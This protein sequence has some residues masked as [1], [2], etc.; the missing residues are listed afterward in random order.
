MAKTFKMVSATGQLGSGFRGESIDKAI[1]LGAQ[2]V[3]CDAGSTDTGPYPLATGRPQ[4]SKA[5]VKRD[6]E[7]FLT[8]AVKAKI[9]VVIG[10]SGTGGNDI[11]VEWQ[12][13]I[14]REIARENGLHFTMATV[15]SE[16]KKETL[17]KLLAAGKTRPLQ[18]AAPLT[19]ENIDEATHVVAMMGAEPIQEAYKQGAQV[20]VCGRASDTSIFASLP[21][22]EG[23]APEYCWHA[24][25]ILECGAAAVTQ[26]TAPDSMM[27]IVN[28]DS[29][30]IFPIREDYRCSPQSIASHT[31]YENADP[32]HLVEPSG[33]LVT[34]GC[35]YEAID[36]R[37]VRV[38]GS[39][40]QHAKEYTNKLE[41]TRLVGYSTILPGA[42]RD[43]LILKQLDSWLAGLDEAIKVRL[44]TTL[45]PDAKYKIVTRVYGRD[46]V[47]GELEPEPHVQGHEVMILWD[48]IADTQELAH[49][50]GS[51]VMHL[52]AHYPIPEWHG[53][54]T[55]VAVPFAPPEV[56]RGP[57]Y[58][59]HLNHVV[60][61][62][63]PTSLFPIELEKV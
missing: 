23:F 21:L 1:A 5:A 62:D 9:P 63:S 18:P 29:F 2:M 50:V 22:L 6:T 33:T 40:F 31:L 11:G 59:F 15:H 51:S 38:R 49:S 24:A 46:G 30:D 44:A 32:F 13:E 60:V 17:R 28:E 37:S 52:A 47:M 26:R 48:A 8:R 39:T 55:G 35:K 12:A 34:S 43:P 7:N 10:S 53:L 54:I 27:G 58:E 20:I 14:I 57:V 4:F 16:Q 36:D 25:K 42:I 45:G 19:E 41:G 3:G 56:N 61:P